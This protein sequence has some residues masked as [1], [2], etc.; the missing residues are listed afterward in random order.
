M[1]QARHDAAWFQASDQPPM[2]LVVYSYGPDR[3]SDENLLPGLAR[4]L[5]SYTDAG[6]ES[7]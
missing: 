7:I 2:L 5:S 4:M 6:D 3:A 1:S